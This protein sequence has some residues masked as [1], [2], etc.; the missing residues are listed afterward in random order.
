M[1]WDAENLVDREARV[2]KVSVECAEKTGFPRC[3]FLQA[4]R[5]WRVA[6]LK[7]AQPPE[8]GGAGGA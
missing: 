8:G 6:E 5:N 4:G 2:G 3:G 7:R 1:R